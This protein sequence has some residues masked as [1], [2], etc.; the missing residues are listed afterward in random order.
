MKNRDVHRETRLYK[1]SIR[2]VLTRGCETWSLSKK[3]KNAINIFERKILR[4]IHGPVKEDEQWRSSYSKELYEAY[5]QLDLLTS[6]KLKRLQWAGHVQ[7]W[8]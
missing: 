6:I 7:R 8:L 3:S 2:I 1:T 5:Q 4:Q